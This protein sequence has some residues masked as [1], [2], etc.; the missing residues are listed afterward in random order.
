MTLFGPDSTPR[1]QWSRHEIAALL[2]V[3]PDLGRELTPQR[4]DAARR[5]LPVRVVSLERGPWRVE[6]P[7]RAHLGLL[8][9][10]GLLG[11]E[12]LAHDVASMEL[13]GAG[14][15]LRP[16][17]ESADSELLEAVVRWSVMARTRVAVLDRHVAGRLAGYPEIH[18]ALLERCV[19]RSRRLVVLQAISQLN[20]VDRR[21]LALLWHLAE[22]WGRVTPKGV[23]V[24]LALSHRMLGQLVGARRPTISAA[25]GE[26]TRAGEVVRG[27]SGTWL[28]TGSPVG[29]PDAE[30]AR[31]VAPRRNVLPAR[32]E[33]LA[34]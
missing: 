20:R 28:L 16:W 30:T 9:L 3:D 11:R 23:L 6:N 24:P 25:L 33:A 31:F 5:E 7:G 29:R 19:G 4:R 14:D 21:V 12:L 26:L 18:C 2:D 27:D 1:A 10:D 22:R 15:L 13:L 32:T 34:G 17:D 8:V